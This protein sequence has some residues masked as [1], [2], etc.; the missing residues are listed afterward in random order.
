VKI[1]RLGAISTILPRYITA[2]AVR[3]ARQQPIVADEEQRD[4]RKTS[5]HEGLWNARNDLGT[6]NTRRLTY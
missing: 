5:T 1:R 6:E 4:E 2:I 3:H